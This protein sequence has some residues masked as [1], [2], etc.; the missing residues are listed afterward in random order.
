MSQFAKKN[1][2]QVNKRYLY[3]M[4]LCATCGKSKAGVLVH[5]RLGADKALELVKCRCDDLAAC[6]GLTH[7]ADKLFPMQSQKPHVPVDLE[8]RCPTSEAGPLGTPEIRAL[9]SWKSRVAEKEI[10]ILRLLSQSLYSLLREPPVEATEV[11]GPC[12]IVDKGFVRLGRMRYRTHET[13]TAKVDT[14]AT[15]LA[16]GMTYHTSLEYELRDCDV[17]Q[18]QL[19]SAQSQWSKLRMLIKSVSTSIG[20]LRCV[21]YMPVGVCSA[22]F[23]FDNPNCQ[24]SCA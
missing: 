22:E 14:S 6:H 13:L 21:K 17:M 11:V 23:E 7:L 2:L 1:I 4:D 19:V 16:P 10:R 5:V 3:I 12:I 9:K 15:M 8:S 24:R 18:P 20:L